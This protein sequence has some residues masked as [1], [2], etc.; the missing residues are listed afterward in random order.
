[1]G[2]SHMQGMV[3]TYTR[4]SLLPGYFGAHFFVLLRGETMSR[5]SL[6]VLIILLLSFLLLLYSPDVG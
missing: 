1:M 3:H 6:I 2:Q 5:H 4:F